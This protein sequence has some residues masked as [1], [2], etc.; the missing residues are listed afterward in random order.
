MFGDQRLAMNTDIDAN[1]KKCTLPQPLYTLSHKIWQ[2]PH[3]AM[4]PPLGI[5]NYSGWRIPLGGRGVLGNVRKSRG[6]PIF[7]FLTFL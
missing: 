1:D 3:G 2:N 5:S 7:L 4:G 6:V